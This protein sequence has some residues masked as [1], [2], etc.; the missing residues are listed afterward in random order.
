MINKAIAVGIKVL[1][2]A[3][4]NLMDFCIQIDILSFY[5]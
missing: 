2:M 1:G 4:N 5:N 3:S